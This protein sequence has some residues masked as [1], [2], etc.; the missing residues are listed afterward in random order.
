MAVVAPPPF[1]P[2]LDFWGSSDSA[3]YPA[4]SASPMTDIMAYQY[5]PPP[6]QNGADMDLP[7]SGYMHPYSV[8]QHPSSAMNVRPGSDAA[9]A[10]REAHDSYAESIKLKRTLSTPSAHS[11]QS[12]ASSHQVS[13]AQSASAADANALALAGEKRRNK[14]GYH[15]TSVACGKCLA[16]AHLSFLML[17]LCCVVLPESGLVAETRQKAIAAAAR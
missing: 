4:V 16:P 2:S 17:R 5:P 14:L 3:I 7:S 6:A 15:R 13:A 10:A 11:P 12:Q 8:P 1:K 9:L